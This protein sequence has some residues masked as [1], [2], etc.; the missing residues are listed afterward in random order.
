MTP[1][2]KILASTSMLP[3]L[4]DFLEDCIED[5]LIR[6]KAKKEATKVISHIREMDKLFMDT[7]SKESVQQ[8]ND[9]QLAFRQWMNEGFKDQ[10]DEAPNT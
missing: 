2:A 7:A 1:K 5:G 10:S 8:Q 9:I 3:V 6:F 4:A